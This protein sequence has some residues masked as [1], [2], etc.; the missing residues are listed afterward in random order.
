MVRKAQ[1]PESYTDALGVALQA[2][3]RQAQTEAQICDKLARRQYTEEIIKQVLA[4][5]RASAL[6]DDEK[7]ARDYISYRSRTSPLGTRH[8]KL[9]L[10]Q[11]G[12]PNDVAEEAT[13]EISSDDELALA[14]TLAAKRLIALRRFDKEQQK[15][16]LA[17]FL[18]ARGFSSSTVYAILK[19]FI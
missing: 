17:R 12:V 10:I 2:L 6:V 13:K 5:L 18:A 1:N 16:K 4:K 9:K 14:R 7:Y 19:E 15:L 8:L 3:A 11:K